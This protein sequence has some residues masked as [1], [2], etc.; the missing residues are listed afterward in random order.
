MSD[1]AVVVTGLHKSFGSVEVL[2]GIDLTVARGELL[3]I[4]VEQPVARA[5]RNGEPVG[6][7]EEPLGR[8][9]HESDERR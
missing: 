6:I 9:V 4:R 3:A 2:R 8:A 5:D 1:D 7:G